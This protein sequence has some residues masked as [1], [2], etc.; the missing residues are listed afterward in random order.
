MGFP[1]GCGETRCEPPKT[2][3]AT[4]CKTW[5]AGGQMNWGPAGDVA[6]EAGERHCLS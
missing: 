3:D 1:G 2:Q 5:E 6:G 4:P